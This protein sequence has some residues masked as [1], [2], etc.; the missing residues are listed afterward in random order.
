MKLSF[1]NTG[2]LIA[3]VLFTFSSSAIADLITL[4]PAERDVSVDEAG[5]GAP[6]GGTVYQ[7]FAT[8][9]GDILAV[10][11][12]STLADAPFYQNG[13][14]SDSAPGNPLLIPSFPALGADSWVTTPGGTNVLGGGIP[15]N[16]DVTFGDTDDD[17]PQNNFQFAQLTLPAGATGVFSGQ[18]DIVGT[19]GGVFSQQFSCVLGIPE[20][21]SLALAGLAMV[22]LIG[23]RRRCS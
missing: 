18:F 4:T 7:F 15:A 22:S 14:G 1:V 23:F 12:V 17:G 19:A 13:F 16:G 20:P 2:S 9:D 10:N 3:A 8:T 21:T 5:G 6:D 11:F